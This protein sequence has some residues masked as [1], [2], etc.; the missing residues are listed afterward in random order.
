MVFH[1]DGIL[2]VFFF[3]KV[4]KNEQMNIMKNFIAFNSLMLP[5]LICLYENA[6]HK[7]I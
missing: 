5:Y 4:K 7:K 3:E 2:E 1:H 6:V